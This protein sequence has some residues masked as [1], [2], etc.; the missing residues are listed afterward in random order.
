MVLVGNQIA[1]SALVGFQSLGLPA[2]SRFHRSGALSSLRVT[3]CAAGAG[4]E[5]K[6]L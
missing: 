6:R 3:A 1:D 5:R 4:S 2:A